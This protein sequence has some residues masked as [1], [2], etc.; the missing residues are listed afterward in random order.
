MTITKVVSLGWQKPDKDP[1][2]RSRQQAVGRGRTGRNI[3]DYFWY[4]RKVSEGTK[5]PIVYEFTRRRVILSLMGFH[6]N[7]LAADP[8]YPWR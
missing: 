8:T 7:R 5:G 3:N 1:F 2:G 4:R 6:K